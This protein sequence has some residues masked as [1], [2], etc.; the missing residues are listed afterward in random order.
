M[1]VQDKLR[2]ADT[3]EDL[4]IYTADEGHEAELAHYRGIIMND[5]G[6]IVMS[7]L[8]IP[9]E[10]VSNDPSLADKLVFPVKVQ[11]AYEGFLVRVFHYN[12][13]FVSTNRRIDAFQSFW[14]SRKTFGDFFEESVQKSLNMSLENFLN[15][16]NTDMGYIFLVPMRERNKIGS[17]VEP[18]DLRFFLVGQYLNGRVVTGEEMV[19]DHDWNIPEILEVSSLEEL[20]ET[21]DALT[22]NPSLNMLKVSCPGVMATPRMKIISPEYKERVNVRG[23]TPN[24]KLRYL[25][26]RHDPIL[27]EKLTEMHPDVDFTNFEEELRGVADFIYRG[28]VSRYI[29]GKYIVLPKKHFTVMA[30]CHQKYITTKRK[31]NFSV[32]WNIVT[33]LEP[34]EQL[35]LIR[36]KHQAI[37]RSRDVMRLIRE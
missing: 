7:N 26:I 19:M 23:N 14:A 30:A 37:Q 3:L 22:E 36:E 35:L 8:P 27:V 9:D 18:Q 1:E 13:W 25:Q 29:E 32:I 5:K 16:L 6:E 10:Y 34:H 15:T 28:Y 24:I 12:K 17:L 2:C 21:V 31:T 33:H 20:R 11:I 4:K